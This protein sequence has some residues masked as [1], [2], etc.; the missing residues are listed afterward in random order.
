MGNSCCKGGNISIN[1]PIDFQKK[2]RNSNFNF[3]DNT[4][5]NNT[6]DNNNPKVKISTG[7]EVKGNNISKINFGPFVPSTIKEESAANLENYDAMFNNL[8]K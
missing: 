4:T 7:V 3:T 8:V 6:N 2:G 1:A 5:S